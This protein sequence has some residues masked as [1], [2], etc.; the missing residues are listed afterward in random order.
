MPFHGFSVHQILR[1]RGDKVAVWLSPTKPEAPCNRLKDIMAD[2]RDVPAFALSFFSE[3]ALISK[4]PACRPAKRRTGES[5]ECIQNGTWLEGRDGIYDIPSILLL[6]FLFCC[7]FV[8]MMHCS[9]ILIFNRSACSIEVPEQKCVCVKRRKT[10]VKLRWWRI[11]RGSV[12]NEDTSPG[13]VCAYLLGF[14][15]APGRS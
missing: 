1:A 9:A 5:E 11:P 8:W 7:R 6:G 13:P 2:H 4:F 3:K 15:G 10:N 14:G 12:I